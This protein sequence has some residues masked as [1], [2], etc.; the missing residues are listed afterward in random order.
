LLR[1][2]WHGLLDIWEQHKDKMAK[3][4]LFFML[5]LIVV[6]VS[7]GSFVQGAET[8]STG[9]STVCCEE[10]N[11]GLFCQNTL[12]EQCKSDSRQVPTSCESTS[13][14]KQGWCYDGVE[15][16]CSDNTPQLV[17]NANG[18]TWSE[19]KPKQCDLGCCILG[20]QAAFVPLVRCKKLAGFLGLETNYDSTITDEVSCVLTVAGQEKGACVYENEFERTCKF[21]TNNDCRNS[22]SGEFFVGKLCTAPELGT[23][24]APTQETSCLPGK[25]EVYFIDSCGNPGNIYDAS[26][27]N[28]E[29]DYWTNVYSKEESCN[30]NS[31]NAGSSDC[32]NCNYLQGSICRDSDSPGVAGSPRYGD[33]ICANLNC[34]DTSNGNSYKHGESWCVYNDAGDEFDSDNSV[35][36]NFYRHICIN[37]EEVVETCAGFRQEVCIED[38]IETASG[39]FSQAACR[40]NRWQDCFAQSD[41]GDC[42]NT[43]RRDCSWVS[44]SFNVATINSSQ[45]GGVCVPKTTPGITFWQGEEAKNI[46]SQAN[47]ACVVTYKKGLFGDEECEENCECLSSSWR[48]RHAEVCRA[49]GDCGDKINWQGIQG[50]NKGFE[51]VTSN[52][53]SPAKE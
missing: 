24:C 18:G 41:K 25:D 31:D 8:V 12:P 15:G 23:N 49:I 13:Y 35:G 30:P 14:C 26:E 42:E 19:T 45:I 1:E 33:S 47:A 52:Y 10:T 29:V 22:F 2:A 38:S 6:L 40:V 48:E 16:T 53:K 27:I 17:C 50:S 36:S 39:E 3:K 4:I 7:L 43:D 34:E 11:S 9:E 32:G 44:G 46:C 5:S 28:D 21:T 51:V 20:D 37:G